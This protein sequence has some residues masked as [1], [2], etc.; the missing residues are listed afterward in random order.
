MADN[1]SWRD[2]R[3]GIAAAIAVVAVALSVLLF[4]RVGALRGDTFTLFLRANAAPGLM[5]G[6]EVWVGG[7]RVGR[8]G[9]IRFLPPTGPS[10]DR[11]LVVM[12]VLERHRHAIRRDSRAQIEPGGSL[13][14]PPVVSIGPGTPGS[15]AVGER[16]T[17]RARTQASLE[18]MTS[19]FGEAT[20][21]LPAVVADVK[22]VNQQLRNP[23]GT[24]G[25]F[26]TE[27]GA[28]ELKAVAKRGGRLAASL[29]RGRGTIGR[30][31]NG[32]AELMA[33]AERALASADS[34][35]QLIASPKVVVGRFRRDATLKST[36]A[37]IQ[38]E[39]SIV[40]AMLNDARG[41][42]GRVTKDRAIVEALTEA[43]REMGAIMAD[44]RRRPFRYLNF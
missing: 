6:S 14:G 11:L 29:G 41:T 24:I 17:I 18:S 9:E 13:I 28:V 38:N 30:L 21:E 10:A 16:D 37:D 34:V 39:L 4:A 7:Q 15:P 20:R 43:E 44:I 2:L 40:R 12:D 26:G 33:R 36:V 5:K 42:A 19:R 27:R 35:Q 23:R 31:L 1:A 8:V 22:R 32:R 25:A 3:V